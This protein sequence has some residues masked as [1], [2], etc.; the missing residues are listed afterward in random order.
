MS[1]AAPHAGLEKRFGPLVALHPLDLELAPGA[2]LAVLGPNGAG[3]STLLR[4]LA[5][6]ARPSA[7]SDRDRGRE[8]ASRSERRRSVGLVGHATFLTPTLTTREN[9]LLAARLYGLAAPAERAARALADEELEAVAERRAGA[10]SRG[11]AQRAAIARALLH[12]P[13]ARAARR[14]LDGPRRAR[15]GAPL[16]AARGREARGARAGRRH[17]RPRRAWWASPSAR[18]VLVRGRAAWLEARGAARASARSTPPPSAARGAPGERAMNA[19]LAVL[20][21]DLVSEWRSRD[22][23]VAM[24]VFALLVVIVLYLAAPPGAGPEARAHVPGLLWVAYLFA[25]VLGLNRAFATEL[26]NE[27][28][29]LLALAPV[30]RG[31]IFLGKALA[32]FAAAARGAGR[33]RRRLRARLRPRPLARGRPARAGGRAR[34]GGP[35][36]AWARS[37]PRSRCA[38]ST[39]R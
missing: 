32:S 12:D 4:L 28:L 10:L 19:L 11:L 2:A 39:A 3:K 5:G 27:A 22:R 16:G 7:G 9:L 21:K 31:W 1:F 36:L 30:E 26:E 6:L 25:G 23:L 37:S 15:R 17:P 24:G 34:R 14:A 38:R 13:Q 35:L 29:S 18:C 8:R 20:W 33:D